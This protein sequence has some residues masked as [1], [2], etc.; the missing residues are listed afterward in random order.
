MKAFVQYYL[1]NAT[2]LSE[3]Q[4]FVPAPQ[5]ALDEGLAKLG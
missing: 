4:Q 2:T 5:E 3:E 1:E